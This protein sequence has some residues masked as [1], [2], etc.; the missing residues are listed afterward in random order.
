MKEYNDH[1]TC[2]NSKCKVKYEK[3]IFTPV[4]RSLYK[5]K[6]PIL[7]SEQKQGIIHNTK[8]GILIGITAF[9]ISAVV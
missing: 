9:I 6:P 2:T 5:T 1:F 8:I 4:K 3:P 7:T